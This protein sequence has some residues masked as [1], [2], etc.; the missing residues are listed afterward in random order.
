MTV[1]VR[2]ATE[3]VDAIDWDTAR[4]GLAERGFTTVGRVLDAAQCD[5]LAARYDDDGAFR[6]TVVMARHGFGSG[7]YRYFARPLPALVADLRTAFYRQLAPVARAWA[8]D[9]GTPVDVPDE[10]DGF[11]E[12]CARHGQA[13]PTPLLLRYGPGDYNKLHQDVYGEVVFP[14]QV[15][16]L[17][18]RPGEDFTG[19]HF[20]LV[21]QRPR[22]Q[23]R[24]EV[25]PLAQ[26]EAV[27]FATR[28]WPAS[29]RRG[30]Y[31]AV[32]RHGVSTVSEGRRVTLG[33]I[34]HDAA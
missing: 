30:H 25:V 34:F 18:S 12:L 33:L 4:A 6:S 22:S 26:G 13:R 29:G 7:E 20:L 10:L 5:E 24:G 32:L 23:S 14:L 21:E 3:A 27:V 2:D 8:P 15:T 17:L 11:T 1:A 31:R 9:L 28:T 19:G 16:I